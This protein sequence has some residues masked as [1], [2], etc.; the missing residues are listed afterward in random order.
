[1]SADPAAL[2]WLK[3][4]HDRLVAD[5]A[6]LVKIPSISNDGEHQPQIEQ[7][8]ELTCEQMRQAGLQNVTTLTTAGSNPYAYGEWL[9]A[10]GKP[11]VFLYA[12]HDVQPVNDVGEVKWQ[13]DPWT[14]TRRD[15]RLYGRGAAD[16]KGADHRP[17]RRRRGIPPDEEGAAGQRQDARRGR[18]GNRLAEPDRLLR[19]AQ[20]SHSV[21]R[22]RRLR[23]GQHRNRPAEHHLRAARHRGG[24]GGRAERPHA[25]AQ[26]GGRRRAGRRRPGA[27]RDP[28]P[29]LLEERPS[30]DPAL[31]RQG[32]STDRGGAAG[33]PGA[34]R[35]R[36]EVAGRLR[37]AAR[38]ALRHAG[39]RR[40]Q[41]A[42]VAAAGRDHHRAGSE[43]DQERVEPGA[44]EGDRDR[45]LPHRAG[46]GSRRGVRG[47]EAA[48]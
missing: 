36:G 31:L 4:N 47:T 46:P 11:T 21:G 32:T 45:E 17:A 48:C 23:H 18:G 29:T 37:R 43:F 6:A 35:R 19:G 33:H 14:L 41:R 5:L 15:G 8:A 25:R 22:D 12:H 3:T 1:M 24:A 28:G 27:R 39:G 2:D 42:D 7:T 40:P 26:R 20:K 13:S 30:A 16:D 44:T 34:A 38:R 10:P 9:G